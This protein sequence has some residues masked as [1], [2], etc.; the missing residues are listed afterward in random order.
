M[1]V[2]TNM[3]RLRKSFLVPDSETF[4][5]EALNS[6]GHVDETTGYFWHEIQITYLFKICP[7]FIFDIFA[8]N[9]AKMTKQ[10]A[11]KKRNK[12]N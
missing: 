6:V 7:D 5:R 9:N 2:A 11:L 1:M 12:Q 3:S 10:K 4:A 8:R